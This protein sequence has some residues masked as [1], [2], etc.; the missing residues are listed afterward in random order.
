MVTVTLA[1]GVLRMAGR[2][3][4]VKKLPSVEALGSVNV[5]CADKTGQW[6][7]GSFPASSFCSAGLPL[8]TLTTN[9]M[10]ITKMFTMAE[11]SVVDVHSHAAT[12]LLNSPAVKLLLRIGE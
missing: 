8:G 11:S 12:S 5:I 7:L 1:L 3:A 9:K 6:R 2:H 10:T 4:I